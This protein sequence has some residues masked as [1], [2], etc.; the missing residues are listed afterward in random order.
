MFGHLTFFLKNTILPDIMNQEKIKEYKNKLE[1]ERLLLLAEIKRDEAP[2][3]F[4]EGTDIEDESDET[5]NF[6]NQLA[7]INGL[8]N[9][10]NEID[11]AL[12]KIQSKE[13][14]VCEKCGKEIEEEILDT[15]PESRY[16]KIC[17]L[18]ESH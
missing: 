2:V 3:D 1:K 13:Y 9:R 4:G 11:I 10:F 18:N 6:G 7:M 14:G 8:K 16:C 15:D 5:E 12:G 17:K